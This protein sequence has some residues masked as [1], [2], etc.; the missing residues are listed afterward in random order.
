MA[1]YW[2]TPE[3]LA[4]DPVV[5]EWMNRLPKIVF[6]RTLQRADWQNTALVKENVPGEAARLKKQSG[7]DWLV[8]GSADLAATLIQNDLIDEYRLMLNPVVLGRG[9][10]LFK[11]V[12]QPLKLSF[13]KSR[14]FKNGNLLLYYQPARLD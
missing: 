13:Q 6:S 3:A 1:S 10:P 5:T 11:G 7:K 2:P 14:P 4:D 8:F 12:E 9:Q